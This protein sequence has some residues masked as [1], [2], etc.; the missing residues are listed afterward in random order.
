M[1]SHMYYDENY[2]RLRYKEYCEFQ[3]EPY[4][5]Q[6]FDILLQEQNAKTSRKLLVLD[7]G[8]GTGNIIRFLASKDI[9]TIGIDISTY[10]ARKAKAIVAS[11]TYLPFKDSSINVILAIHIIEHLHTHE[12]FTFLSECKRVGRTP[13][14]VLIITPNA[15]SILRLLQGKR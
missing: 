14:S 8:C 10:A 13:T 12:L 9:D 3:V 1:R 4:L 15:W 6:I 7:V 5:K 2:Y 11:A